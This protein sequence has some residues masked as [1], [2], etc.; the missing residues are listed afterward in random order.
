MIERFLAY[1]FWGNSGG[2]Y[3]ASLGVFIGLFLIFKFAVY[4]LLIRLEKI[5]TLT[6]SDVDDFL[7][8]L[9]KEIKPPFYLFISAYVALQ[10]IQ[11]KEIIDRALLAVFLFVVA[12]QVILT[13][14]KLIDFVVKKIFLKEDEK[15]GDKEAI[16]KLSTQLIK[17]LL[18]I[19]GGLTIL[20]NLGIDVTSMITGLGIGGIA[21]ALA[22]QNVLSDMFASFSIF[23]DKP[24][25]VGDYIKAGSDSGT[26]EKIGI[27]TT[28]LRTLQGQELIISNKK[29]T[30][31][32][33]ENY[34]RM[35]KRRKSFDIGV[36]YETDPKKLRKI[37]EIL[38]KIIEK[39]D[40]VEFNRATLSE[41][42]SFSIN[43]SVVYTL[44]SKDYAL[45]AKTQQGISYDIIEAFKKEKIEFA[46]PT[47]LVY[48]KKS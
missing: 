8:K 39:H 47:Q 6:V 18:W 9:I 36:L 12:I 13:L 35:K 1:E 21:I 7:I 10:F 28:R 11:F 38:E 20:S 43:Y 31:S 14:Q 15:T 5:S 40:K 42:G 37:P 33:I 29:M 17:A 32:V 44:K 48:T 34:R 4:R 16:I 26:V 3:L 45:Y 23:I 19:I 22:L 25:K 24:F 2:D 27:K 46:Y 30:D 41:F